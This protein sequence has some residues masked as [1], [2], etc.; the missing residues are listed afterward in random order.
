MRPKSKITAKSNMFYASHGTEREKK[1]R[2]PV[3][4]FLEFSET[5][6]SAIRFEIGHQL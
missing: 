1:H 6:F 2:L 5:A 3:D 4:M